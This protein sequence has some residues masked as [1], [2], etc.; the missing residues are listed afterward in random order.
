MKIM[1]YE[2]RDEDL[3]VFFEVHYEYNDDQFFSASALMRFINKLNRQ[4]NV[5]SVDN[6]S[7]EIIAEPV[8]RECIRIQ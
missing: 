7:Y 1:I 2:L 8:R 5:H 3:N 4:S 6:I